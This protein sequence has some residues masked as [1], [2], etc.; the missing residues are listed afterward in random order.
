[1]GIHETQLHPETVSTQNLVE[2]HYT[3]CPVFVAS[4]I[5]VE[6]GWLDEEF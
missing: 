4:N 1:M 5:A 3:I 2:A 6:L